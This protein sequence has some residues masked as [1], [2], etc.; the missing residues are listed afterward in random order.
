MDDSDYSK[1]IVVENRV[2]EISTSN[3]FTPSCGDNVVYNDEIYHVT[4]AEGY[5]NERSIRLERPPS[6]EVV[7]LSGGTIKDAKMI[8][9]PKF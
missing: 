8:L 3:L 4:A 7:W 1:T 6:E 2:I 9:Y 5:G